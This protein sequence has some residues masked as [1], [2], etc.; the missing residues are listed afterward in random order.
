MTLPPLAT[1]E[2]TLASC[3]GVTSV[4]PCPI[5]KFVACP[6]RKRKPSTQE[7]RLRARRSSLNAGFSAPLQKSSLSA[8]Q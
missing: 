6:P 7:S 8:S 1:V 4:S 3:S 2:Y 5:A